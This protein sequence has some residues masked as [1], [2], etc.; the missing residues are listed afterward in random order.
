MKK[1]LFAIITL[2]FCIACA[3]LDRGVNVKEKG[4]Q[5]DRAEMTLAD[6]EV[7]TINP[8]ESYLLRTPGVQLVG[9]GGTMKAKVR[10]ASSF[11]ADSEPLF[12][13]NG[14]DIGSSYA[15][16]AAL[17]AGMEIK[18]VRVLKGPDA[19]IYGVRGGNGVV[20]VKAR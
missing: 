3:P 4:N 19:S 8:L 16:A 6:N 12:I 14:T 5:L 9:E 18:S 20:V 2:G 13:V 1:L 10:G 7:N 15:K 17:V 11:Y